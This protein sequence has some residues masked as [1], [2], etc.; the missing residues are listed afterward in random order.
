VYFQLQGKH[1]RSFYEPLVT[2]CLHSRQHI[3][4]AFQ[5]LMVD[6]DSP[7]IDFYPPTFEI[8]MNGKKLAWQGVALLPFIDEQRLLEAMSAEYHNLTEEEIQRNRPGINVLFAS[9][10]HPLYPFYEALYGKRKSVEVIS[11]FCL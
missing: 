11:R 9:V 5:P 3:P 4:K 7:I 1:Q 2:T 10:D 8:D 6:E